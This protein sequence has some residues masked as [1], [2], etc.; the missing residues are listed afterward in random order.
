MKLTP[1]MRAA[2]EQAKRHD[3]LR[4]VHNPDTPGKPLWPAH[5]ATIHALV[6]HGLVDYARTVNAKGHTVDLWRTNEA[7]DKALRPP[8]RFRDE[9]PLYLAN[10]TVRFHTLPSGRWAVSEE[11]HDGDYSTDPSRS[12]DWDD[13]MG[14][15]PQIDPDALKYTWRRQSADRHAGAQDRKALARQLARGIR[16]AA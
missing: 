4:R 9:R 10:G 6:R 3:G 13:Q 8:E 11:D 12:V 7:G 14:A 5:P 15:L 1:S 16:R 2:L